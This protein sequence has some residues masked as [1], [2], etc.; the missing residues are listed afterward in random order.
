LQN[1]L[2]D[3][4]KPGDAVMIK[5]SNGSKMAPLVASILTK[6]GRAAAEETRSPD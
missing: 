5:G 2:L 4:L 6:F 1:S 3:A